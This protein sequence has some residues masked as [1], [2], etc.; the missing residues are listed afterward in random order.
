[1]PTL[2]VLSGGDLGKRF[3]VDGDTLL[4]R[5]PDCGVR[6]RDRSISRH[7]ARLG[8][9]EDGWVLCDLDSRNGVRVGRELIEEAALEDLDE[10]E[11]GEVLIRFRTVEQGEDELGFEV[12][13]P[14]QAGGHG[15][16]DSSDDPT[17][18]EI[19]EVIDLSA[20]A[21]PGGAVPQARQQPDER[22]R[23]RARLLASESSGA[24]GLLGGDLGQ[25]P[26][27]QLF[28]IVLVAL[29]FLAGSAYLVF[30]LVFGLRAG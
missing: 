29:G 18:L 20:A 10:F 2:Y 12:G 5:S 17:S 21:R 25:R 3:A 6:L 11:L 15:S 28:L 14:A 1:M 22:M 30:Q 9:V 13:P 4:G 19:E 27:W 16:P 26:A 23:A 7:H 8:P 24:G